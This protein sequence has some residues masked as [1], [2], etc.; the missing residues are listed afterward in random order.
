MDTLPAY[1]S[2]TP[3]AM[4]AE[5]K[6]NANPPA[7]TGMRRK[8]YCTLIEGLVTPSSLPD[9]YLHPSP[10]VDTDIPNERAYP[11]CIVR[12]GN[13]ISP[14]SDPH[15]VLYHLAEATYP[16]KYGSTSSS[17]QMTKL[18]GAISGNEHA[19]TIVER[20]NKPKRYTNMMALWYVNTS[21]GER[22]TMFAEAGRELRLGHS[23]SGRP[24][25]KNAS[26]YRA[27]H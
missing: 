16:V 17:T 24:N 8:G 7:Q 19:Y 23:T 14:Q 9:E 18:A 1:S 20:S 27:Q 13:I 25:A 11:K 3:V 22:W 26:L 4:S 5:S 10:P 21:D 2:E 15:F 6:C 12:N